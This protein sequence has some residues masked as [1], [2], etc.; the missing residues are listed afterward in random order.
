MKSSGQEPVA[1]TLFDH[2]ERTRAITTSC[3]YLI[4][5]ATSDLPGARYVSMLILVTLC[6]IPA[7]GSLADETNP[8][9]IVP[10]VVI[11]DMEPDDRIALHLVAALF[12]DRLTLV[13]TTVMHSYRKKLLAERL[14]LQ[15][16]LGRVPVAQGSGGHANSYPNIDSSAAALAYDHEGIGILEAQALLDANVHIRS[17]SDLR[18][19][20]QKILSENQQVEFFILAPPTDLVTVLDE[21]P[22][23]VEHVSHIHL[24]GGW[25]DTAVA[26]DNEMRTTY[27]WNMDPTSSAKLLSLRDVSIT[28]YSSHTIKNQFA[29]GSV[30]RANYPSIIALLDDN[31][32][33]LPSVAETIVS[34]ASWDNHVMNRIPALENV[35]G[36]DNAGRQFSP[37]DP[38]VVIGAYSSNLATRTTAVKLLL[39]DTDVDPSQGYRIRVQPAPD[40]AID[41]VEEL[42]EDVFQEIFIEAFEKLL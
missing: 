1:D 30:Q 35:I 36:R 10:L 24:M 37:A 11:T 26:P 5:M 18:I 8:V 38:I 27:N 9:D 33:S 25:V 23:L 7:H 2:P 17:S 16:G 39:D 12:P 13:G 22:K 20:L 6:L 28:L 19:A 14:L 42:D 41:L 3:K 31:A 15:L 32:R 4:C 21:F 40:S 29:G 34:G